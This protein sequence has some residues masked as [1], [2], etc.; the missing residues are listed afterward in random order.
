MTYFA[1]DQNGDGTPENEARIVNTYDD[2]GHTLMIEVDY[3]DD[4][5]VD[6]TA[7]FTYDE[8]GNQVTTLIEFADGV[9]YATDE[10]ECVPAVEEEEDK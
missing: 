5:S 8:Y 2:E 10:Y 6:E 7:T 1:E 4:G 3:W 9:V